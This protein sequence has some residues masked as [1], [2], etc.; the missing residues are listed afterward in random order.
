MPELSDYPLD[1]LLAISTLADAPP[2]FQGFTPEQ[3]NEIRLL[4]I[5]ELMRICNGMQSSVDSDDPRTWV[6]GDEADA[7]FHDHIWPWH[8]NL[9]LQLLDQ[10][11][12]GQYRPDP[13]NI[14]KPAADT[15]PYPYNVYAEGD[16]KLD[17]D[18]D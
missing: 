12:Q 2:E 10:A 16:L 13:D 5:R 14:P 15:P 3:L 9:L 18:S 4:Q 17:K 11:R 7:F 6:Y 8:L 1:Q